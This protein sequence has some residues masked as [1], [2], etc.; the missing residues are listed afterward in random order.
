MWRD[1]EIHGGEMTTIHP[2]C[3]QQQHWEGNTLVQSV[4]L[5]SVLKVSN[6]P[7]VH[8]ISPWEIPLKSGTRVSFL[9]LLYLGQKADLPAWLLLA[10]RNPAKC[11]SNIH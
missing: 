3:F 8:C 6:E 1:D 5:D 9:T 2:K 4:A 11:L 10:S 7:C